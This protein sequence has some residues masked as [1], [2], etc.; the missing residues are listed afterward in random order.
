VLTPYNFNV[1]NIYIFKCNEKNKKEFEHDK[2]E[3]NLTITPK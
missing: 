1:L 3:N 2:K